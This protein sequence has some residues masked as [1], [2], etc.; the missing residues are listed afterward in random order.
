MNLVRGIL[1]AA[2]LGLLV[3]APT[4]TA[5]TFVV[6]KRG[7]H[8]PKACTKTDCTLREAVLAANKRN[9]DDRIRLPSRKPYRL[10]RDAG[11]PGADARKGDLNLGNAIN[12][13]GN[14]VTIVHPG[15][16]RAIVDASA[17]NDRAIELT[18]VATLKK[19]VLRRGATLGSGGAI[20]SS[21]V[22]EL[23]NTR[24][25][26]NETGDAGGAIYAGVGSV[27][28]RNTVL[29]RNNAWDGGGLFVGAGVGLELRRSTV[30][31]NE[32]DPGSGGGIWISSTA[33][34]DSRI[35]ASTLSGNLAA[36]DGGAI[37][38][39]AELL[40]IV[41]STLDGNEADGR[42]G[43]IYGAPG[44]FAALNAVTIARNRADADD[45]GV[46]SGG[47]LYGDGGSD[48]LEVDNSLIV[49]NRS[50]GGSVQECDTPAP[51][52]IESLGGNLITTTAGGCDFFTD[53]EDLLEAQ[54]RVG[55]L[56]DHGGPTKTAPLLA[57][58]PAIDEADGHSPPARD[59]RG[60]LRTN[61]DIGAFER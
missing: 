36:S 8:P 59:Q 13:V 57:G 51:V 24:I 30:A 29:R 50:T 55:Q 19:I 3:L 5:K 11:L 34:A 16:G 40:R 15:A 58:S 27:V 21:G 45:A 17:A 12:E 56:G 14:A 61:P 37:R 41:N 26:R 2:V 7:D 49:R 31:L 60:V 46:D 48:V 32:A 9:G 1:G 44:S 28:A 22:L 23:V 4:A 39:S 54:P 53:P 20:A 6:N 38:T 18:G 43:G 47:G 25:V 33:L 35:V 10:T 42:G 52:G